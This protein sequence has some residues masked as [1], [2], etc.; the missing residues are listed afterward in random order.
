MSYARWEQLGDLAA[1]AQEGQQRQQ[2]MF[3][4]GIVAER[5]GDRLTLQR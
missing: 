3:P 2:H 1:T 5:S 4:G